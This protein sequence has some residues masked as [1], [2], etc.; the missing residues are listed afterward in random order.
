MIPLVDLGRQHEE[1]ADEVRAGWDRVVG[2]AAFVLGD[3]VRAF[4]AAFASFAG[5]RD[6]VGVGSGTDAIELAL[7][8]CGVGPGDEVVV[9]A[10]TFA[11][12]A[13]A[14]VRCGARPVLVDIEPDSYLVDADRVRERLGPRTRAIVP[15]HLYGQLARLEALVELAAE[16]GLAVVEDAAQC[17]GAR[18]HGR[19][20]GHLGAAAATSFYPSK[21]LGAYG[22]A[23]AVLTRSD[24]LARRLRALRNWGGD[25]KYEHRETGFNS[26]LD[27]LQAVVLHA[28]LRRLERWNEDRRAAA[29]R[30][31]ERLAELPEVTPPTVLDGNE[32]VWHLYVIRVP[33]RDAVVAALNADGIGAGIHYP[34]PIH[35]QGAFADLGHREGDFPAAEATARSI[36]SLPI[37]PGIT[38]AQQE[39]VVDSLRRA[40]TK[41]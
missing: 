36:V 9:P 22:D 14:V 40:L 20:A 25:S 18:R 38:E 11:A 34:V 24:D 35:L 2:R 19:H 4:E 3:E 29:A 17:H 13:L 31:G 1:I 10:N 37:Y 16:A 27:T 12:T 26:R 21:N 30:Y 6:C 23:G 8:A 15:V 33:D 7:R 32:H 41:R 28:K 5:V 39:C